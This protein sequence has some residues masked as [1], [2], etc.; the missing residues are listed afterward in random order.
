MKLLVLDTTE[1]KELIH[2]GSA[3]DFH[4]RR[5]DVFEYK[6]IKLITYD[7]Q[8]VRAMEKNRLDYVQ[9]YVK[10]GIKARIRHYACKRVRISNCKRIRIFYK[11]MLS[12]RKSASVKANLPQQLNPIRL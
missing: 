5:Y 10:D 7:Q 12:N 8:F 6:R 11:R 2:L 1:L 9:L 3:T 4:A